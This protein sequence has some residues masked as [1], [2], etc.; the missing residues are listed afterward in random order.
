MAKV[1]ALA[2]SRPRITR[3]DDGSDPL[4]RR[5]IER[6]ALLKFPDTVSID[7]VPTEGGTALRMSSRSQ[8]GESDFGANE[9]RVRAWLAAL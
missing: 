4:H 8:I 7:A 1:D 6:T 9:E 2:A 3:V 5:Y